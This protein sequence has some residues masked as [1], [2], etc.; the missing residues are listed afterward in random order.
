VVDGFGALMSTGSGP[1]GRGVESMRSSDIVVI[2]RG[3]TDAPGVP[4]PAAARPR[5]CRP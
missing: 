5:T 4:A 1:T 2:A 3:R